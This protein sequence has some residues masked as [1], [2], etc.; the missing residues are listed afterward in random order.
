MKGTRKYTHVIRY[1][2]EVKG[3][4]FTSARLAF[5][6]QGGS[7]GWAEQKVREYS[8]GQTVEVRHHPVR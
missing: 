2:Y 4:R 7:K 6:P 8:K 1:D 3:H 5:S